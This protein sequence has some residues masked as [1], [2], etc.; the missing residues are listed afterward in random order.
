MSRFTMEQKHKRRLWKK[1]TK[2]LDKI[3]FTTPPTTEEIR[4]R[5]RCVELTLW[6]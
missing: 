5:E 1:Y 2:Q 3:K 4:L 6:R